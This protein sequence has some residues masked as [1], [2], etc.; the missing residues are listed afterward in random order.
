M[1]YLV[2]VPLPIMKNGRRRLFR[3]VVESRTGNP[4]RLPQEVEAAFREKHIARF[5]IL[6]APV[7]AK[8][9]IGMV[10][11]AFGKAMGKS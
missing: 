5:E 6:H 2:T 7:K 9:L 1:A 3:T 4:L 11:K 8:S 10:S